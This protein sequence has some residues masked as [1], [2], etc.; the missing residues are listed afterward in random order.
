MMLRQGLKVAL[1]VVAVGLLAGCAVL[2]EDGRH[3]SRPITGENWPEGAGKAALI[4]P[5]AGVALIAD[6]LV[7]HPL[8]VLPKAAMMAGSLSSLALKAPVT[9]AKIALPDL[10]V[11]PVSIPL[12]LAGSVVCLPVTEG[13]YATMPLGD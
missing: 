12:W 11:Y 13:Y 9:A 4:A 2:R 3:L 6:A 8:W 10:L 7:V 1:V 5:V